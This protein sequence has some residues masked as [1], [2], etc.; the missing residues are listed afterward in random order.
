MSTKKV[1]SWRDGKSYPV[2]AETAYGVLGQIRK[3]HDVVTPEL[4]LKASKAKSSPLHH[5]FNWDD[6]S[7]GEQWRRWQAANLITAIKVDCV[8]VKAETPSTVKVPVYVRTEKSTYIR[9]DTA[10]RSKKTIQDV[11][12][13]FRNRL[14]STKDAYDALLVY[15]QDQGVLGGKLGKA[16]TKVGKHLEA[17]IKAQ[18]KLVVDEEENS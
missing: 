17:T 1:Y 9:T 5:V 3:K 6:K 10:C 13:S 2:D 15:V 18:E 8:V 11:L 14:N 12:G 4:L 16:A 7:C